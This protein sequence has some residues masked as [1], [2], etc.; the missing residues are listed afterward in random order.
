M[1]KIYK[2]GVEGDPGSFS[3]SGREFKPLHG[4]IEIPPEALPDAQTHGFRLVSD[5]VAVIRSET[6]PVTAVADPMAELVSKMSR[7]A[8]LKYCS[9]NSIEVPD[10]ASALEIRSKV[11]EHMKAQASDEGGDAL[12]EKS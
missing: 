2:P 10:G 5:D 9:T 11:L 12:E 8:L 1:A 3:W 6:A 4:V 7:A